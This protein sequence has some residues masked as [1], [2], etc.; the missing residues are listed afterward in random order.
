MIMYSTEGGMDIEAVAEKTP[1]LIFTEEIDDSWGLGIAYQN[2][3]RLAVSRGDQ[4]E[5]QKYLEKLYELRRDTPVSLQAG[6]FLMGLGRSESE[7]GNYENARE[8]FEDALDVFNKLRI[9]IYLMSAKSQ[10]GHIF[11]YTGDLAGAKSIYRET[12]AGWKDIGNRGAIAHELESFAAIAITEEDP[13]RALK[14]CGAAEALRERSKSPM[15]DFERLEYDQ[16]VAHVRSLVDENEANLLW[17][18]GRSLTTD[19]AIELA[20]T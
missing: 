13:Q 9:K 11:R 2:M 10:L 6:L 20:L 15:T 7:Q 19:E 17:A 1:H 8:L 4:G 12:I 3:A 5:K 18:E 16:M 14:L